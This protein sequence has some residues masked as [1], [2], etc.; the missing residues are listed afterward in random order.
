MIACYDNMFVKNTN[1]KHMMKKIS[2]RWVSIPDKY[3]QYNPSIWRF[4]KA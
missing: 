4:T 1:I 3:M 2:M